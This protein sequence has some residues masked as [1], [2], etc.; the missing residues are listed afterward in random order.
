MSNNNKNV[1]SNLKKNFINNQKVLSSN[2]IT[3]DE[4]KK[5]IKM[6]KIVKGRRNAII[7]SS[8]NGKEINKEYVFH[9]LSKI[10]GLRPFKDLYPI[11]EYLSQN[12][13][14]FKKIKNEQGLNFLEKI[15]RISRLETFQKGATIIRFGEMGDKFYIVLEGTVEIFK[16]KF[17]EKEETPNNF[18][19][20][21][22]KI[23]DIERDETKYKRIKNK[24]L[25]FFKNLP[26]EI[27][28]NNSFH[29]G[30]DR[31]EYK[32][33]FNIEIDE[34][35]GEYKEDFSFGEI[36]LIKESTRNATIKAK[37]NCTL[38]TISNEEY[39]KVIMDF[40]KRK[41]IQDIE[42]FIKTYSFFRNFDN[43]KV[44]RLFNCF[45]KIELYRGDF[46]Y[47]QNMDANSIYVLESGSFIVYSCISFPWINDYIDYMDYSDKNILKFLVDNR[48]I[49]IDDLM[50]FLQ[51]FQEKNK[52][53]N[54]KIEQFEIL[55]KINDN[56]AHDNLYIIKND[57]EKLNT[58]EYI[59]Q[60]NLKKVDY[61]DIIGLEE[62]FEFKKRLCNYKCVSEKAE[63]KEIKIIDL[64]R[65]ILAMNR[66]EISD[67]LNIIQE[68][69]KLL[70]N[71]IIHALE[72]L[73][74]KLI[75]NFDL[76]YENLVKSKESEDEED[77][78][79]SSLKV[80]GY[81]TSIQDI[82]DKRVTVFPHE[83]NPTPRDILKKIKRKNKSSEELLKNYFKQKPNI[84]DFKFNKKMIN[85]KV[86][87]NN[88]QN[89]DFLYNIS[90]NNCHSNIT[91]NDISTSKTTDFLSPQNS[92]RF[93][94]N[95]LT[96]L[97]NKSNYY[98]KFFK[99]TQKNIISTNSLDK[100]EKQN[101]KENIFDKNKAKRRI[102]PILKNYNLKR[103]QTF[104][105]IINK[106]NNT[107]KDNFEINSKL[108]INKEKDYKG[109]FHI[110]NSL[111]KNFFKGENFTKKFKI[112]NAT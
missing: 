96:P 46:L 102:I 58:S 75:V 25:N 64:M 103:T 67:L 23:K 51:E 82:L 11:A 27:N 1:K 87:K 36:A 91:P 72:N 85:I 13:N 56:Q 80:K 38:L 76:R 17:I 70:K 34:K 26:E 99:N 63:L 54:G 6:V 10:P 86:I 108:I 112:V 104:P 42:H 68:R 40:Q 101:S 95:K 8:E 53:K 106:M 21:L 15:T 29:R 94:R 45:T 57:E 84:N 48:N 44:I 97:N 47:K 83:E 19:R 61:K 32:Q 111:D 105:E 60:L 12:Y 2:L 31:M 90:N 59:F 98:F 24:N 110:F 3:R 7:S 28:K 93:R 22:K 55:Y 74:K 43:D 81:K 37:E 9:F 35:M 52:S 92:N 69:K 14:Y 50:K 41:L 49:K 5:Q 100:N 109:F 62:A 79:L 65:L 33:L 89:N 66:K 73:D 78:L 88:F 16:P 107:D 77:K 20:E 39:N 4:S 18:L 30:F 71:Q